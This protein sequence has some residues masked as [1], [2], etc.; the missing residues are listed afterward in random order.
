M[1][2][3]NFVK[4]VATGDEVSA[5][6]RALDFLGVPQP[7]VAQVKKYVTPAGKLVWDAGSKLADDI[8]AGKNLLAIVADEWAVIQND[9][10]PLLGSDE[11]LT[12]SDLADAAGIQ[13]RA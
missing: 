7:I 6:C 11:T 8:K 3:Q 9:I 12:Q 2:W 4:D 1:T 13:S 10:T 5:L